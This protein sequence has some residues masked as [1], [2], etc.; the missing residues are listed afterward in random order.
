[1][2]PDLLN[3]VANDMV[4]GNVAAQDR[5]TAADRFYGHLL[6][7]FDA[8]PRAKAVAQLSLANIARQ[9]TLEWPWITVDQ[10]INWPRLA[11]LPV[12]ERER[13]DAL[14]MLR[15]EDVLEYRHE[16]SGWPRCRIRIPLLA[17]AI[18]F[19]ADEIEYKAVSEL[20]AMA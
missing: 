3:Q 5:E 18:R 8:I 4:R 7:S 19:D 14:R 11:D 13:H 10:A 16:A 15:D 6:D 2:T 12:R 1:V 20:K 17:E 9:V